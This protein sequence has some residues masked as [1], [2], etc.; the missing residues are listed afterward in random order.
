MPTSPTMLAISTAS[1]SLAARS[2]RC[3]CAP[4]GCLGHAETP[5][6]YGIRYYVG[7]TPSNPAQAVVFQSR[8]GLKVFRDP[9]V[10]EPMWGVHPSGCAGVDRFRLVSRLPER[11]VVEADLACPGLAVIGDS[12][13]PGWRAFLD[14]RRVVVQ[15]VDGVRAVA[16]GAGSHTIEYRYH[17]GSV[18]LGLVLSL[19]GLAITG[20]IC[21]HEPRV[22]R[23]VQH[24]FRRGTVDVV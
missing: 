10:G 15:E 14:G 24:G 16:A 2:P 3:R 4:T 11:T 1:N 17:P 18:Y 23:T 9:R 20:S 6:T 7:R 8:S 22:T 12:Y 5:F 13:Y 19:T 21:L